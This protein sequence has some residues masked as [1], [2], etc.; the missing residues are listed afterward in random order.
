MYTDNDFVLYKESEASTLLISYNGNVTD[1]VVPS[2]VT[3][4]NRYAFYYCTSL[5]SIEIP[6][7]VTS[8]GDEAFYSCRNLT[9]IEIPANVTSIGESAFSGCYRLVEVVNKSSLPIE[10]GSDSHGYIGYYALQIITD[11]KDSKLYTENDFVLYKESEASTLLISY[12]GNATDIVVP[13]GV[14]SINSYAFFRCSSLTSI[15]IPG[16][17]ESIGESAFYDCTNLTSITFIE[18]SL[19]TSIGES[20]FYDCYNLT[21]VYYTG[22]A[23]DWSNIVI[24]DSGNTYLTYATIYYYSETEPLE[25]GNYWHYDST[26]LIVIW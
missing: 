24:S 14:T 7:N 1:I 19:L 8:I 3:S 12:I 4:I 13:S 10:K 21:S 16:S 26:G 15:E 5:T 20:A 25:E 23:S 18:E 22:T 9:S 17:V 6:A 11:K 2:E